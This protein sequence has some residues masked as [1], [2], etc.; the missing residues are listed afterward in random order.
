MTT[1]EICDYIEL[2]KI[3]AKAEGKEKLV[4]VARDI[5]KEL[6]LDNRYPMVCSAMRK[7]M[8]DYDVVLFQP[9]KKDSSTV[10]IEYKL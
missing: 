1:K 4:L 7:C 10:E 9:P 5:H 2:L 8:G 3:N 6:N